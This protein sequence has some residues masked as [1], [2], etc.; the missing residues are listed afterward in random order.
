METPAGSFYYHYDNLGSVANLTSANGTTQW[1]YTY[2]PF[3]ATRTAT[4]D[5]PSAPTNDMRFAGERVDSTDLYYLRAR[6]YDSTNGRFLTID[7]GDAESDTSG[8]LYVGDQPTVLTDPSGMYAVDPDAHQIPPSMAA[9]SD[10]PAP[11]VVAGSPAPTESPAA[12]TGSATKPPG[13]PSASPRLAPDGECP[14]PCG[15]YRPG[16]AGRG[17]IWVGRVLVSRLRRMGGG[18]GYETRASTKCTRSKAIGM[19]PSNYS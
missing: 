17:R 7:P 9:T 8:Y 16:Y 4:Q 6:Q 18:L 1:T 14:R 15:G 11:A 19:M 5:D 3:G 12:E 2:E 13:S 10:N